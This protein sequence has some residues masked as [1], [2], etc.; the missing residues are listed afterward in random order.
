M[1]R[2][3][4]PVEFFSR[5][6]SIQ[7]FPGLLQGSMGLVRSLFTRGSKGA[8]EIFRGFFGVSQSLQRLCI[9]LNP[10]P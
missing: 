9:T 5:V 1:Y 4:Q 6:L 7:V 3:L 2:V 10:K 8:Q